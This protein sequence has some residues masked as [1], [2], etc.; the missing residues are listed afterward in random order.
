M[1]HVNESDPAGPTTKSATDQVPPPSLS[2]APLQTSS[3]PSSS[4]T[5]LT[6]LLYPDHPC[7]TQII[8]G[9]THKVLYMVESEVVNESP[10]KKRTVTTVR[11]AASET[12]IAQFNWGDFFT[13]DAV[14]L[15]HEITGSCAAKESSEGKGS[16]KGGEGLM[17][18]PASAWLKKSAVPFNHTV[19]YKDPER[20]AYKWKGFAPGLSLELFSSENPSKA[21]VQFKKAGRSTTTRTGM[22]TRLSDDDGQ[23]KSETK[24]GS[25]TCCPARLTIDVSLARAGLLDEVVVAFL[26]LEKVRRE[27]DDDDFK[28]IPKTT[29]EAQKRPSSSRSQGV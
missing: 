29:S 14:A 7:A 8:D 28:V 12:V 13:S 21:L 19:T 5:L 17:T 10:R 16:G 4:R 20:K 25:R 15:A 27:R 6:L 2:F 11:R 18:M 23:T 22:T 26:Y 3:A 9:A 1:V 24:I